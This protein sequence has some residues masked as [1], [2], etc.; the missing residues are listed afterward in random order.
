[1][2]KTKTAWLLGMLFILFDD[3][4]VGA[5][6]T[7]AQTLMHD[8][9]TKHISVCDRFAWNVSPSRSPFSVSEGCGVEGVASNICGIML[10][11]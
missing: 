11:A 1:M 10:S 8:K 4:L 6:M 2:I 9:T 3:A 7:M 5:V